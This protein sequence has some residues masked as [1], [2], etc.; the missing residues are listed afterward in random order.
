M[1]SP[2]SLTPEERETLTPSIQTHHTHD[3]SESTCRSLIIQK[4]SAP[5]SS[6]WSILRGFPNPRRYKNFIKSCIMIHGDGSTVGSVREVTVISGLPA[7]TSIERLEILDDEKH[8]LS[9]VVLGGEHRLRNYRSVTTVDEFEDENRAK[10]CVVLE[11]YIVDVPE[12][13]SEED[14]KILADTVVKLNLQK[15][16]AA[17]MADSKPESN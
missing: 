15:L 6:V 11:S 7:T 10:Y 1:D 16:A 3:Q 13:N 8:V 12:G 14:T 2:N 9:F 4:I 5:M 17:A